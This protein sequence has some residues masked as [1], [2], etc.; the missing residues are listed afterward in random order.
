VAGNWMEPWL[1]NRQYKYLS[2]PPPPQK[3]VITIDQ[4][5]IQILD[6]ADDLNVVVKVN[7]WENTERAVVF[8]EEG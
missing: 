2:I 4:C 3:T 1:K 5:R 6:L 8:L 7:T